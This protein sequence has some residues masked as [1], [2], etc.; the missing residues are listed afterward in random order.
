M[1]GENVQLV[2]IRLRWSR[3]EFDLDLLT[4]LLAEPLLQ[5]RRGP[6]SGSPARSHRGEAPVL[7]VAH[8]LIVSSGTSTTTF[9]LQGPASSIVTVFFEVLGSSAC[10][11]SSFVSGVVSCFSSAISALPNSFESCFSAKTKK[12]IGGIIPVAR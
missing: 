4:G 9:F 5:E 12:G 2:L 11:V 10:C 8:V 1:S 3:R 7:F 6:F